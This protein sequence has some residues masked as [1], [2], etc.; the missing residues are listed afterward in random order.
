MCAMAIHDAANP[1]K[2][3]CDLKFWAVGGCVR[4]IDERDG[5]IR[6]MTISEF[7]V[8]ALGMLEMLKAKSGPGEHAKL[9]RLGDAMR[10]VVRR[11]RAQGDPTDPRVIQHKINTRSPRNVRIVTPWLDRRPA[12]DAAGIVTEGPPV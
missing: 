5:D 12:V 10:D 2:S 11:A 6:D 3:Y 7:R 1:V 9:V 4:V 8:R